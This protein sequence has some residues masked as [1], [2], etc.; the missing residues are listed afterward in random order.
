MA[1]SI[2]DDDMKSQNSL[3]LQSESRRSKNSKG[4]PDKAQKEATEN[5]KRL[6]VLK[7]AYKDM[8]DRHKELKKSY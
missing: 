7:Q 4:D 2:K 3:A 1:D 6:K 5:K 8:E